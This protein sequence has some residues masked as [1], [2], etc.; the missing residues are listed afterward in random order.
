[1][2]EGIETRPIRHVVVD[3]FGERIGALKD[4]A[5]PL[6]QRD[7]VHAGGKDR[8]AVEQDLA[9]MTS[10]GREVVQPIDRP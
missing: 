10:A 7:D 3:G 6:P 4:H 5:D 1:M 9:L 8:P 2:C